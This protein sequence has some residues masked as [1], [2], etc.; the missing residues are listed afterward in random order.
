VR[1]EVVR[2]CR[3]LDLH[4]AQVI[5][6]LV[7]ATTTATTLT[8]DATRCRRTARARDPHAEARAIPISIEL[9]WRCDD[10]APVEDAA[11]LDL[12]GRA[13]R[14]VRLPIASPSR[15]CRCRGSSQIIVDS[16]SW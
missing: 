10:V 3:E 6:V 15:W 7:L 1:F 2:Q 8:G 14:D 13:G 9:V 4:A 16:A 12:D 11:A 5:L